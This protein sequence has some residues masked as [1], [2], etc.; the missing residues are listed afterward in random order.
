MHSGLHCTDS[1]FCHEIAGAEDTTFTSI[2]EGNPPSRI[3]LSNPCF[4]LIADVSPLCIGH[5]L[6]LP[7]EHYLSFADLVDRYHEELDAVLDVIEPL[8]CDTFGRL[9]ILEH[10]SSEEMRAS[11]CISHAHWHLLPIDGHDVDSAIT[12]DSL[13]A[14]TFTDLKE[15]SAFAGTPYFLCGTE[16]T[17]RIYDARNPIRSQ[18]LR[19]VAGR[20]LGISTPLW[21]YA[22]LVRR[23]LLRETITLTQDWKAALDSRGNRPPTPEKS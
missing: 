23:E 4:R 9:T 21:D 20:I 6:L 8:Y 5:L 16:G 10:G 22:L 12:A 13:H 2:Y 17:Y 1:D 19:S 7:M 14:A 3:I 18:Y 11:A 15:I